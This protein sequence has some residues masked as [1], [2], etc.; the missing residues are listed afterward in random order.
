MNYYEANYKRFIPKKKYSIN[1][2]DFG[3][4]SGSFG[5][6]LGTT[7]TVYT[8]EEFDKTYS[9]EHWM[10]FLAR[11]K[12]KY[13][14]IIVKEVLYYF[15]ETELNIVFKMLVDCLKPKGRIIIQVFNPNILTGIYPVSRSPEIKTVIHEDLILILVTKKSLN[16]IYFG[17]EQ[18][19]PVFTLFRKIWFLLLKC[20]Y[21]LERG[22]CEGNPKIYS[23][24]LIM[25]ADKR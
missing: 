10:A 5:S 22:K 8:L 7:G 16:V 9:N 17:G 14:L 21:I 3:A 15:D 2:L 13:D 11:S 4:G 23:K 24:C 18:V 6:W 12:S 19:K 20:I 1:I 25:I